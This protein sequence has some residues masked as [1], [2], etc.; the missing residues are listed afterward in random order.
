MR[1][2][3]AYKAVLYLGRSLSADFWDGLAVDK[4]I[5][6]SAKALSD[7]WIYDFLLSD[8]QTTPAAGTRRLAMALKA[9]I[10]SAEDIEAK[11]EIAAAARLAKSLNGRSTS[12]GSFVDQF[13]LSPETQEAIQKQLPN[14]QL[15]TD[16]FQFDANE[17]SRILSY[18]SVEL[19]TGAMLSA[20]VDQFDEVFDV[21]KVGGE[22][23]QVQ[24][25]T[26][27]KVIDERL[28]GSK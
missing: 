14:P 16:R 8:F 3:K 23:G 18:Q 21:E 7:Y 19:D 10:R 15:Q 6:A 28:K 2:E 4:Q 5:N 22:T 25:T 24:Y 13:G 1:S 9:V 20:P 11:E 12:I 26:K 27:G 17:F